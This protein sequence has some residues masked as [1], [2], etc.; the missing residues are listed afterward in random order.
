MNSKISIIILGVMALLASVMAQATDVAYIVTSQSKVNNQ[1][2]DV[3]NE[4]NLSY[5]VI[6]NTNISSYDISQYRMILVNNE[7][8]PNPLDIP[9]NRHPALMVDGKNMQAWGWVKATTKAKQSSP[10][11]VNITNSTHPIARGLTSNKVQVYTSKIPEIYYL[12]KNNVYSGVNSVANMLLGKGN[13]I[14]GTV[15]AGTVLQK[16]SS[17]TRVDANS[18]FFGIFDTRYWTANTRLL[19]KNS[20]V[21]LLD[22]DGDGY[23]GSEDCDETNAN[24]NIGM[25]EVLYNG[26]DD[27]CNPSTADDPV[28]PEFVINPYTI[29]PEPHQGA[30]ITINTNISEPLVDT[31]LLKYSVNGGAEQSTEMTNQGGDLWSKNI[32]CYSEGD[33]ISYFIW[34]NDTSGNQAQTDVFE[35]SVAPEPITFNLG[36]NAGWNLISIPLVLDTTDKDDIFGSD[37]T[38]AKK[39]EGGSFVDTTTIE[40]NIGYFVNSPSTHTHHLTGIAPRE[41][42]SVSLNEGMNL[43]GITSLSNIQLTEL[44]AEVTEVYKRNSDGSYTIATK[45]P[46][47]GWFNSF[48]L[49]PGQGYWFKADSAVTWNYNP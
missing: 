33:A 35:F 37:I 19:F 44:P 22:Q 24:V 25:T 43:V 34:A 9:V 11:F 36:L 48:E 47:Y 13:I 10:F 42:Q 23:V 46:V 45:Y 49:E 6:L 29:P 1:F 21:W 12:D 5:T 38:L 18:V 41:Q 26:K 39:F 32:G 4:L 28:A 40:N 2:V 3:M 20:F 16:D 8:F 15:K 17:T 27:D 30:D 31:V 7:E 14:I